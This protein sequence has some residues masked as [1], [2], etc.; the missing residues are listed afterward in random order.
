MY[1]DNQSLPS[2]PLTPNYKNRCY[3]NSYLTLLKDMKVTG[4]EF[5][6][7]SDYAG[8][9]AIYSFDLNEKESESLMQLQR[10]GHTRLSIDFSEAITEPLTVIIY[11]QFPGMLSIDQSR[12]VSVH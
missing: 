4:S 10:K 5:I 9:Y 12:T 11:S 8:G 2:S 3:V 1:V 6:K 7:R